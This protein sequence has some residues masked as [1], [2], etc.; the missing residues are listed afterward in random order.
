MDDASAGAEPGI[1][2]LQTE[3][4]RLVRDRPP[5]S[6]PASVLRPVIDI[7]HA[8]FFDGPRKACLRLVK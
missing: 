6:W 1:D 5:S 7:L 2:E 4:L 8:Q 3:L